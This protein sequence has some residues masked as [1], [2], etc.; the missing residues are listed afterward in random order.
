MEF[1]NFSAT[2]K[3]LISKKVMKPDFK[4]INIKAVVEQQNTADWTA[5]N[6]I[7]KGDVVITIGAGDVFKVGE[8]LVGERIIRP[9]R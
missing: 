5:K 2:S 8:R 4:N 6:N 7:K 3:Y 9:F 1:K